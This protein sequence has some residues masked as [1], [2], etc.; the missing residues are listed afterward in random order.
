VGV[1]NLGIYH[2]PHGI[3]VLPNGQ[4]IVTSENP[5]GL[6]LIDRSTARWR[7]PGYG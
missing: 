1:I 6:L 4:L 2:R 5:N 3:A 7:P